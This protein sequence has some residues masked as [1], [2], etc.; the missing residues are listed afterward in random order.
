MKQQYQESV[1]KVILLEDN[2]VITISNEKANDN[3]GTWLP[4]W[5]NAV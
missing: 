3:D 2:D 4:G 5:N 1:I